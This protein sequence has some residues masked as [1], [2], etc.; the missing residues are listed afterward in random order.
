MS[1]NILF[2]LESKIREWISGITPKLGLQSVNLGETQAQ[3]KKPEPEKIVP[4]KEP[5]PTPQPPQKTYVEGSP[6]QRTWGNP[7]LIRNEP[8][9]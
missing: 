2:D 5:T 9:E 4:P 7:N 1:N 8:T 6:Q 3:A